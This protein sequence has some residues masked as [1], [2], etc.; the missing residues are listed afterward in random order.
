VRLIVKEEERKDIEEDN[1]EMNRLIKWEKM[2]G[3][4]EFENIYIGYLS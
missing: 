3:L 1:I 4:C 2:F